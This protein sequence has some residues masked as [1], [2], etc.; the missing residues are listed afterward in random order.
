MV[1]FGGCR[2][3]RA[4]KYIGEADGCQP[5]DHPSEELEDGRHVWL[6]RGHAST[7]MQ[8]GSFSLIPSHARRDRVGKG[9]RKQ[10]PKVLPLW[11]EH[12]DTPLDADRKPQD[13]SDNTMDAPFRGQLATSGTKKQE[14]PATACNVRLVTQQ[15]WP[16]NPQIFQ[17][18]REQHHI[19]LEPRRAQGR[20]QDLIGHRKSSTYSPVLAWCSHCLWRGRAAPSRGLVQ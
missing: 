13:P 19:S 11:P 1:T 15:T 16:D 8:Y 9:S 12:P 17:F 14:T 10:V 3:S 5:L 4:A 20:E 6:G 2:R 18:S 7:A